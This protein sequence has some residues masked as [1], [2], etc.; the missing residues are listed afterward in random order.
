MSGF[1]KT[2]LTLDEKETRTSHTQPVNIKAT[3]KTVDG[4]PIRNAKFHLY[5]NNNEIKEIQ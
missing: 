1:Y 2:V 5:E 4:N 3:L